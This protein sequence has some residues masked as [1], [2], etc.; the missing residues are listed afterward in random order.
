M[1]TRRHFLRTSLSGLAATCTLPAFINQTILSLDLQAADSPI[2]TVTG[3]DGTILVI[4][5]MGGGNDGL[6]TVV[7]FTDDAYFKARSQIALKG[8][9]VLKLND[10]LGLNGQLGALKGLYDAG[11]MSVVNGVGYPNPNRSH[12]RSMEIWQTA[13]DSNKNESTGWLGRYFDNACGGSDPTVGVNVGSMNPQAFYSRGMKGISLANPSQYRSARSA[14]EDPAMMAG[15]DAAE[16]N[17][18]AGASIGE[19]GGANPMAGEGSAIDFLQR[20]AL[21]AQM[22]SDQIAQIV[23]K[24]RPLVA[25]PKSKLASS[26]QLVGQ[27]IAGGLKT[28]VFYVNQGG[29]DTHANQKNTHD[30]LMAELA[31]SLSAFCEDLKKQGNFNRVLVLTFSEFGRRLKENASGGTDHGAAGPMFVLGGAVKPGLFGAYPSLTDLHDGDLKYSTDFRS[32]YATVLKNWLQTD[33]GAILKRDFPL[34]PIV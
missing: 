17:S 22:S 1:H 6:N 15:E 3:K 8:N 20:T 14:G 27:L 31:T 10:Q 28:R 2:Q 23:K 29:Y 24:F 11:Q 5:Q 26:L 32:V 21:D 7:P 13:S 4:V 19:L 30:R 9:D 33:P 25:Y 12:F 34:L 16:D 18:N